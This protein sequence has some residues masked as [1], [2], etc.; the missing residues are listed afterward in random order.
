MAMS[1]KPPPPT[2]PAI[3]EYPRI[4]PRAMVTPTKRDVLASAKRTFH[5]IVKVPAPILWAASITPPFTS[6]REDST[7]L[8]IKGAAAI[9]KGTTVAV[10]PYVFPTM[11]LVIGITKI[12]KNK[13]R[14][15]S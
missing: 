8:A 7:I 4:V 14:N 15:T 6:L 12:N 3:A 9:T 5:I 11:A 1:P 10:E 2:T 13:K